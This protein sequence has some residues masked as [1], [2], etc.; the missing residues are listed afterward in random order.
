MRLFE[1]GQLGQGC[2]QKHWRVH[3][4]EEPKH[5]EWD[6]KDVEGKE[7]WEDGVLLPSRL[8]GL[9]SLPTR[10]GWNPDRRRPFVTFSVSQNASRKEKF[11]TVTAQI[12]WNVVENLAVNISHGEF[13]SVHPLHMVMRWVLFRQPF[14]GLCTNSSIW[15]SKVAASSGRQRA[16]TLKRT[17]ATECRYCLPP[18]SST[19]TK[20][21]CATLMQRNFSFWRRLSTS[22]LTRFTKVLS[23]YRNFL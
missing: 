10:F 8:D 19:A 7:E 11:D 9:G 4:N 22:L 3:W 5:R 16:S 20:L 2:N 12:W 23:V 13:V 14:I 6:T 1:D 18:S 17:R 15:D 21:W